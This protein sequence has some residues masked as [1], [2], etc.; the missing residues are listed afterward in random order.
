MN[1]M[2]LTAAVAGEEWT[3]HPRGASPAVTDFLNHL[4]DHIPRGI[5]QGLAPLAPEMA[6]SNCPGC[7]EKRL[8]V[9]R[10]TLPD[11]LERGLPDLR[12]RL[13]L[14]NAA[15]VDGGVWPG[16]GKIPQ[17]HQAAAGAAEIL[18]TLL[19][20]QYGDE[21]RQAAA[22]TAHVR[23]MLD[24]CGHGEVPQKGGGAKLVVGR[25][26]LR[27]RMLEPAWSGFL[28]GGGPDEADLDLMEI[29]LEEICLEDCLDRPAAGGSP[30][31][32]LL[33]RHGR[34]GLRARPVPGPAGTVSQPTVRRSRE[35]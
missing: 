6:V 11:L 9:L 16:E 31:R 35:T 33:G 2:E 25:E 15:C 32:D 13:L 21:A 8:Q 19:R 14:A 18:V 22:I 34:L 27:E 4:V 1:I 10:E 26:W 3:S 17:P 29:C 24:A 12:Q 23:A 28:P 7:E 30:G 20:L 5:H